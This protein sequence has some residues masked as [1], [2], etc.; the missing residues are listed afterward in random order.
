MKDHL[1]DPHSIIEA[2]DIY[3]G[4]EKRFALG[5]VEKMAMPKT[6]VVM[7]PER[8]RVSST[9]VREKETGKLYVDVMKR[10][11]RPYW[12]STEPRITDITSPTLVSPIIMPIDKD[13]PL[14][15]DYSY[16]KA[17][18]DFTLK[19][20]DPNQR[21]LLMNRE[22]HIRTIASGAD[23]LG[24]DGEAGR[25]FI[26][27]EPWFM[28]VEEG[29][30]N[31]VLGMRDLSGLPSNKIRFVLH[32]RRFY[33]QHSPADVTKRYNDYY[34]NR[35][36]TSPFFWTTEQLAS[37]S[38]PAGTELDFDIR[39]T[40]DAD[41]VWFKMTSVSQFPFEFK[42]IEKATGRA[43]MTDF[44]RVENGFGS[45]ELPFIFFEPIYFEAG[46]KL[47]LRIRKVV[48]N[49]DIIWPTFSAQKIFRSIPQR[50][51][52]VR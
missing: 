17:D 6:G 44:V 11:A 46:K 3:T 14:E 37:V 47:I 40:D 9:L 29:K 43:L 36:V 39:I 7:R 15:I 5:D 34:K 16:F 28:W 2:Y 41:T 51:L 21:P 12:L 24:D 18:G 50:P 13:G 32:G 1:I 35:P 33:N 26:W 48:A 30:R 25:P 49:D 45:A 10:F 52:G 38:G 22:I 8:L 23:V 19:I 42:I 31:F 27:A 4:E 20:M